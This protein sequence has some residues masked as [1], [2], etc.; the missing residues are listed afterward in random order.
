M[1][2][3]QKDFKRIHHEHI[4]KF[5]LDVLIHCKNKKNITDALMEQDNF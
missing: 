1:L 5:L 3:I 2:F 4:P